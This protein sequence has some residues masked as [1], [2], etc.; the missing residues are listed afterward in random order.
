MWKG[1]QKLKLVKGTLIRFENLAIC[2]NSCKN[3]TVKISHS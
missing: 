2:S 1:N 3:N